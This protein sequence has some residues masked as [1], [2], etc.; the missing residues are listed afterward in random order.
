MGIAY[1]L[2]ATFL[3]LYVYVGM[4]RW[5]RGADDRRISPLGIF[6][7]VIGIFVE[8]GIS[9]SPYAV[10]YARAS[11]EGYDCDVMKFDDRE[12]F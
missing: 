3:P 12:K 5:G 6:N 10:E 7:L 9:D 8:C 11:V 4:D 2:C 1:G